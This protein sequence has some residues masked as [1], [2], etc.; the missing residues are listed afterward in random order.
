MTDSTSW[1]YRPTIGEGVG[2]L[3]ILLAGFGNYHETIWQCMDKCQRF[4]EAL[5]E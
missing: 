2:D 5:Y 3:R 1:P 4:S